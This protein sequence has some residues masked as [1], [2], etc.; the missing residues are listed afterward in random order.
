[1]DHVSSFSDLF[2]L[3]RVGWGLEASKA[4]IGQR[5]V[6]LHFN[7]CESHCCYRLHLHVELVTLLHSTC[8]M[9]LY[10]RRSLMFNQPACKE[11]AS[12]LSTW[13]MA[14]LSEEQSELA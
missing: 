4:T 7:C 11:Y 12:Q 10:S 13:F 14:S 6:C 3:Y 8:L 1:M 2:C 5:Y 9:F